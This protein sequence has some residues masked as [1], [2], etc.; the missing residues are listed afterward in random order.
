MVLDRSAEDLDTQ[1][2]DHTAGVD[3]FA[4][5]VGGT[6]FAPLLETIK[7]GGHY[8]TAGAIGGPV[9]SLDLRTLYLNDLTMHGATVLPPEVFANLV[10]YIERGEIKPIVADTFP[11]NQMREAQQAFT[12]KNHVGAIVIEI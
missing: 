12:A 5:V 2:M 4:D 6:W 11:L 8:A 7:R 9:V 1:V 3:V 10:G